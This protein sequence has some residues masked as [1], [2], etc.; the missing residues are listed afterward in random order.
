MYHGND[1]VIIGD[2]ELLG[3]SFVSRMA[4]K[5]LNVNKK[6]VRGAG[7]GIAT[8]GRAVG[9]VAMTANRIATRVALRAIRKAAKTV[10]FHGDVDFLG[11]D[12]SPVVSKTAAKAILMPTATAAVAATPG[13]QLA[14]PIVP[15]LVNQ[16]L[17]EIY[18][19]LTGGKKVADIKKDLENGESPSGISPVIIGVGILVAGAVIFLASKKRKK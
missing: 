15:V 3:K 4:R 12:G 17:D 9:H 5:T 18:K 19:A 6:I 10:L 16:V 14:A 2:D 13:A 11:A 7:H 1:A 8:A